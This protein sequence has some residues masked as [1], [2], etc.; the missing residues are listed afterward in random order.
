MNGAACSVQSVSLNEERRKHR[1]QSHAHPTFDISTSQLCVRGHHKTCV[2][3]SLINSILLVP[4]VLFYPAVR[5]R[6][7]QL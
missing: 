4:I 7:L 6:L 2:C 1:A 5:H 3:V